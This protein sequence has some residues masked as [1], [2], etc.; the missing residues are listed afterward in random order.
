[1]SVLYSRAVVELRTAFLATRID[2]HKD[3]LEVEGITVVTLESLT[4]VCRV[5]TKLWGDE[6]EVTVEQTRGLLR[7]RRGANSPRA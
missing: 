4:E 1:M 5:L 3:L 6:S 2:L 7:I